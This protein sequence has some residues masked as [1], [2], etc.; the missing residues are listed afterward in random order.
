MS[1]PG[2][3]PDPEGRGGPRYWDGYQWTDGPPQ[4]ETPK[5]L[6][7]VLGGIAV[8]AV[9]VLALIFWPSGGIVTV[10]PQPDGRSDRP[11]VQPWNEMSEDPTE[12][13]ESGLGSMK[14]CPYVGSPYSEVDPDGRQRGGGMSVA[15][16]TA[17]GWGERSTYMPWMAEQNST[18]REV[19]PGW[20]ASV[21]IGIVR[22]EDGFTSPKQAANA[23]KSCMAS[24][25]LFNTFTHAEVLK[26]E[27]FS[28][29]G[30]E[31][32]YLQVEIHV[33]REDW[34]KGDLVDIY[35]VD[36]G[37][38][39]QLSTLIGCSTIDDEASIRE[40]R[41]SLDSLRVE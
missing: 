19:V 27:P 26:N 23:M 3:Y 30:K 5:S 10:V 20:V 24:S 17:P 1:Q 35:V 18:L 32:W 28:V 9:V 8:I 21:D 15:A 34:V 12:P 29:D 33:D 7:W 31:G 16:P 40:V 4:K 38:E 2:W 41:E 25:W 6:W 11:T 39:G 37:V 14:E 22:A 13:E 36:L